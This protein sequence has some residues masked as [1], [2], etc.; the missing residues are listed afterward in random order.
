MVVVDVGTHSGDEVRL[1]ACL[2]LEN[3]R[4]RIRVF[5]RLCRELRNPL[6]ALR[7]LRRIEVAQE[8]LRTER[9]RFVM[10]E[11]IPWRSLMRELVNFPEFIYLQG[12]TSQN[13]PG[14]TSLF[15][16]R[17]NLG[18]SI[19]HEKPGLTSKRLDVWNYRFSDVWESIV[20]LLDPAGEEAI[21]LRINAEGV[22]LEIIEECLLRLHPRPSVILGSLGDVKK[23]F[24]AEKLRSL[25]KLIRRE[26]VPFIYFT[27]LPSSWAPGLEK[28]LDV[29]S[30]EVARR[31]T[32]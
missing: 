24:G 20:K 18:H 12:V 15:L 13:K 7:H 10:V 29:V 4:Q 1:L 26:N 9:A 3:T 16:A 25:Q 23:V 17:K 31:A 27:S 11:P 5:L 6:E 32:Q 8:K 30:P 19:F 14:M 21:V 2:N 22:E 28:L